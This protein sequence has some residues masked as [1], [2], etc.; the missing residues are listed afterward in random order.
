[1]RLAAAII[2]VHSV[3]PVLSAFLIREVRGGDRTDAVISLLISAL[4]VGSFT[5]LLVT[6]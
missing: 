4:I 6:A 3:T 1:M 2:F 5:T